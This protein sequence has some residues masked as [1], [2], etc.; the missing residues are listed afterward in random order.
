M[1]VFPVL[2]NNF[3]LSVRGLAAD[4]L[5]A[6]VHY[7]LIKSRLISVSYRMQSLNRVFTE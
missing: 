7:F 5:A 6:Y 1:T 3:A 4:R 2:T